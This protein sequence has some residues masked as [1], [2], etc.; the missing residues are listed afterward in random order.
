MAIAN[1]TTE[2]SYFRGRVAIFDRNA[3]TGAVESGIYAG[4]CPDLKLG[5]TKETIDHY[6]SM[7]G[8]NRLDR[9]IQK[10]IGVELT[11]TLENIE[12]TI[13]EI[14]VWGT[15][16]TVASASNRTQTFHSG[17]QAG[18]LLLIDR[19]GLTSLD[20]LKDSAGSPATLVLGTDYTV[21]LNFGVIKML[22]V[23]GFTQPFVAQFDS[24]AFT[25]VPIIGS[26][27]PVRFVRFEGTNKGNPGQTQRRVF[28]FYY[29]PLEPVS[30]M[31]LMGDDLGK[32]ELK[33]SCLVDD[34]REDDATFGP[35]GRIMYVN[36]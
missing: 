10:T 28:E 1:P 30:E 20:S 18:D 22:N 7:S 11:L 3:T 8:L 15:Q 5:I 16:Q 2:Y 25:T 21:D 33:S 19:V 26:D 6:E 27:Q 9:R 23:T 34:T 24:A 32:F 35:F 12:K 36:S 4:N 31:A 17:V 13:A 14:L 29:C